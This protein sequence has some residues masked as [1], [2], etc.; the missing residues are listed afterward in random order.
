MI[1]KRVIIIEL[2]LHLYIKKRAI[3]ISLNNFLG[4]NPQW[5]GR[6]KKKYTEET[7]MPRLYQHRKLLKSGAFK[8]FRSTYQ[9]TLKSN[10]IKDPSNFIAMI[11]KFYLDALVKTGYLEDDSFKN[12]Y[13][14]IVLETLINKSRISDTVKIIVEEI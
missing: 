14:K 6:M 11:E 4:K 12:D 8:R 3:S 1:D 9:I 2:P 5:I 10:K 7:I 13:K